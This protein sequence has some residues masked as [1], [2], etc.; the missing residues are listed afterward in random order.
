MRGR[1]ANDDPPPPVQHG[2][3]FGYINEFNAMVDRVPGMAQALQTGSAVTRDM[4]EELKRHWD[5]SKSPDQGVRLMIE[6]IESEGVP[7]LGQAMQGVGSAVRP[8][9]KRLLE[10]ALTEATRKLNAA[11][12]DIEAREIK[13]ILATLR[14]AVNPAL[15]GALRDKERGANP[16][17]NRIVAALYSGEKAG[18]EPRQ[19]I[20]EALNAHGISAPEAEMIERNLLNNLGTAHALR[21]FDDPKNVRILR[22]GHGVEISEDVLA[23]MPAFPNRTSIDHIIPVDL[24]PEL[25]T[26]LANLKLIPLDVNVIRKNTINEGALV[27]AEQYRRIGILTDQSYQNILDAL[28]KSRGADGTLRI[29]P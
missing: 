14:R 15:I 13:R 24:A 1:I 20:R 7:G 8:Q 5:L 19:L 22:A 3:F 17:I 11:I 27:L 9:L 21:L 26:H 28:A 4:A 18:M 10:P 23:H 25:A 6:V 12:A 16:R 2:V 29:I